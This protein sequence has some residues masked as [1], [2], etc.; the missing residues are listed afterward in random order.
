M[1]FQKSGPAHQKFCCNYDDVI[2]VKYDIVE[3]SWTTAWAVLSSPSFADC[4]AWRDKTNDSV[5]PDPQSLPSGAQ[6]VYN[7]ENSVCFLAIAFIVADVV[8]LNFR[9]NF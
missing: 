4:S 9:Q 3:S 6:I 5:I 2:K 1:N 7:E 8:V